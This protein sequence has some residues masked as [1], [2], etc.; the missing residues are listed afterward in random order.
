MADETLFQKSGPR[1]FEQADW[2][3]F[4]CSPQLNTTHL[5]HPEK[6]DSS[7]PFWP[8]QENPHPTPF[9]GCS[10]GTVQL[11]IFLPET[12]TPSS[13]SH[14][15]ESLRSMASCPTYRASKPGAN[16]R[17]AQAPPRSCTPQPNPPVRL[18][19]NA[20]HSG[21]RNPL[22][23]CSVCPW[24]VPQAAPTTHLISG[25]VRCRPESMASA[26]PAAP[27]L[28]Q[29]MR[30]RARPGSSAPFPATPE[31]PKLHPRLRGRS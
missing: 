23:R 25:P 5:S 6:P 28:R 27:S 2:L 1:C 29:W 10:P 8:P 4:D 14:V 24:T 9:R 7:I 20:L 16:R 3:R 31:H 12:G 13:Q 26:G 21:A 30:D 19:H 11:R 18:R 15:A 17:L 22:A